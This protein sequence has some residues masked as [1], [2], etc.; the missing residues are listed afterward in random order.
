MDRHRR[1]QGAC[2]RRRTIWWRRATRRSAT[3]KS[4]AMSHRSGSNSGHDTMPDVELAVERHHRDVQPGA[5]EDRPERVHRLDLAAEQVQR[6]LRAG[7]VGDDEIVHRPRAAEPAARVDPHRDTEH[8]GRGELRPVLQQ[9]RADR[10]T[11]LFGN[12]IR[13]RRWPSVARRDPRCWSPAGR[14]SPTPGCGRA[15]PTCRAPTPAPSRPA[16][17]PAARRG[18][19][20]T[21]A[22]HRT[23]APS[24]RR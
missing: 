21:S 19:A 14:T 8:R 15:G 10:R 17:S 16:S 6:H 5:V 22:A 4:S 1:W 24:P 11:V 20:G 9:G 13:V 12:R 2:A 7:N 23:P 3:S 18:R